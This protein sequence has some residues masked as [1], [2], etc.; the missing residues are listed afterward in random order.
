MRH[1]RARRLSGI[2]LLPLLGLAV[3]CSEGGTSAGAPEV[4]EREPAA[5]GMAVRSTPLTADALEAAL[6][7]EVEATGFTVTGGDA[8][9]G[10]ATRDLGKES[11]EPS[12]CL[13]LRRVR[14]ENVPDRGESA[15][16]YAV[17]YL[18]D[19]TLSPRKTVLTSFPAGTARARM[20]ELRRAVGTCGRFDVNGAYGPSSVTTETLSVPRLGEE[21]VRYRMLSRMEVDPGKADHYAYSLVTVVRVGGVMAS[22]ETGAVLGPLP[23]GQLEELTPEPG[24]DERMIAALVEKV[25]E[26]GGS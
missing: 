1:T 9:E 14:S 18:G 15:M 26:A 4:S 12:Q 23:S 8:R 17:M 21:A 24:P 3:A 5:E 7:T 10:A 20:A 22:V 19:D 13:A 2:A 11:S 16:A 25:K 6:L